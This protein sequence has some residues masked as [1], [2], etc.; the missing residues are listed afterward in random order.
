MN[1]ILLER[2]HLLLRELSEGNNPMTHEPLGNNE[3]SKHPESAEIFSYIAGLMQEVLDNDAN[4]AGDEK[5]QF[6][7]T[8]DQ[9]EELKQAACG[10]TENLLAKDIAEMI[11]NITAEN[12][13]S[14][15]AAVWIPE[16][17]TDIGYMAGENGKSKYPTQLGYENG[18]VREKDNRNHV[19]IKY[20]PEIVQFIA[21]HVYDILDF[22]KT[23]QYRILHGLNTQ[24]G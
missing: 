8:Y 16:Y 7:I 9:L 18:L 5:N 4:I 19:V 17:L 10:L 1:R 14:R 22:S 20:S 2:A 15:F 21:E 24:E 6:Y 13:C 3:L 23:E 11:N 12:N